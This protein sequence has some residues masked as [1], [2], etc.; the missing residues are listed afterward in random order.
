MAMGPGLCLLQYSLL[1]KLW[2]QGSTSA[3][4]YVFFGLAAAHLLLGKQPWPTWAAE[5]ATQR[6]GEKKLGGA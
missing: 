2:W 1:A 5:P 4:L 6:G 3:L